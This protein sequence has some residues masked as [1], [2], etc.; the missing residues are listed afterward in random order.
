MAIIDK[1]IH[2]K[3][4]Y[5]KYPAIGA[6]LGVEIDTD[7]EEKEINKE[8]FG[9]LVKNFYSKVKFVH[10]SDE[11]TKEVLNELLAD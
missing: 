3:N 8:Y 5:E 10:F 7:N 9:R 1:E 2:H 6:F 4:R 11:N